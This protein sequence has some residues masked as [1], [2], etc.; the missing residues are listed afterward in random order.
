MLYVFCNGG[1]QP[2]FDFL[3]YSNLTLMSP[4]Q[5]RLRLGEAARPVQVPLPSHTMP[6][7][8]LIVWLLLITT[9]TLTPAP[10][11]VAAI[12]LTPWWCLSCGDIGTADLFQNLLLFLPVGLLLR[13]HNWS[14][15]RTLL[16]GLG[17]TLL[18]EVAQATI[19]VG[20]DAALGDV[21]ANASGTIAGW[22]LLPALRAVWQPTRRT[23]A[24]IAAVALTTFALQLLLSAVLLRPAPGDARYITERA[25]A[26]RDGSRWTGVVGA[27]A[28]VPDGDSVTFTVRTTWPTDAPSHRATVARLTRGPL[29]GVAGVSVA[30]ETIVADLRTRARTIRLRSPTGMIA[31][32]AMEP[33]DTLTVHLSHAPGRL[34]MSGSSSAGPT[35]TASVPIGAQHGW[36]LVNPFTARVDLADAWAQWTLAWLFGWGV[37]VGFG[38][39]ATGALVWWAIGMAVVGL[40]IPWSSGT[41]LDTWE[42][43]TLAVAWAIAARLGQMRTRGHPVSE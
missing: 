32:P 27:V 25:P 1:H 10:D 36:V 23:A 12:A 4:R 7:L 14:A 41:P 17:L 29:D 34:T 19:V 15:P 43:L 40:G 35:I 37:V 31:M 5:H 8:A 9:W 2:I 39:G 11:A 6:R 20:R 13:Q 33:G 3:V 22:A 24:R 30:P 26:H 38:A 42:M 18:I 28:L 16:L 21:V